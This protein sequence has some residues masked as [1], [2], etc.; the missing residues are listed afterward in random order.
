M[1]TKGQ[2]R[3]LPPEDVDVWDGNG[4]AWENQRQ[5]VFYISL[6]KH[7]HGQELPE[8]SLRRSVLIANTLRQISLETSQAASPSP[9][10]S[11]QT[12]ENTLHRM[13]APNL[14]LTLMVADSCSP[15]VD[16]PSASNHQSV[17]SNC[18]SSRSPAN[19]LSSASN[20][21]SRVEVEDGWE[22]ME[23]DPDF[24]LSAAISSILTALDSTID[25][26]TGVP[27]PQ[28]AP[29]VPL[30]SLEN[31]SGPA[32]DPGEDAA[33]WRQWVKGHW[34][35]WGGQSD[36]GRVAESCV[37]V[38]RSSYLGDVAVDD[39]FQDIDTSLLERDMGALGVR[40]GDDLLRYLPPF[41]SSSSHPFSSLSQN[42]RC[43]PSFSSFSP[44]ASSS[45]LS[46]PS[47]SPFSG[48]HHAR[49]GLEL[50]HLMEILVES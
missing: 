49:E 44:P 28:A 48:Q 13:A 35:G 4:A 1:M 20:H 6:R 19:C 23:S 21:N 16:C 18:A 39:L 46:S 24:S 47:S 7:Q 33:G 36:E 12:R 32:G 37:E 30:R 10:S 31:L 25:G 26:G 15:V 27:V 40:G 38:M 42:L 5:V 29:R 45:P 3:K 43:L 9:A 2:K 22:S 34:G 17:E 50:E 41:P 14:H 8:P 11:L